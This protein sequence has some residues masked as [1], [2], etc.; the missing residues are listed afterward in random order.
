M[1]Q[2]LD[3]KQTPQNSGYLET[4]APVRRTWESQGKVSLVGFKLAKWIVTSTRIVGRP[5]FTLERR[6]LNR[7][8]DHLL[9]R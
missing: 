9:A 8:P 6:S 3:G 2:R 4:N 5:L 1:Q 7:S